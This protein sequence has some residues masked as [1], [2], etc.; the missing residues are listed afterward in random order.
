MENKRNQTYKTKGLEFYIT[1]AKDIFHAIRSFVSFRIGV[2]ENDIE[3]FDEEIP[4]NANVMQAIYEE[5][6]FGLASEKST[7]E[8]ALE[9]WNN[10]DYA[11]RQTNVENSNL[12]D[13]KTRSPLCLTGREI[14]EIWRKEIGNQLEQDIENACWKSATPKPNQ[15]QFKEFNPELFKA[16]INKFS[17]ED[18]LKMWD[19]FTEILS[20]KES[21]TRLASWINKLY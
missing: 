20:C 10:L 4:N 16:Y 18:K 17:D 15:K 13:A 9:W 5:E 19:L 14:E 11:T 6:T 12:H 2:T 1:D 21:K 7:R 3:V 8:L